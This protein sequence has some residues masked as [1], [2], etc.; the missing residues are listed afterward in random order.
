MEILWKL[1]NYC[2]SGDIVA[3]E[4]LCKWRNCVNGVF[5]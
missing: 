1:S 4:Q 2:V 5:V 3:V